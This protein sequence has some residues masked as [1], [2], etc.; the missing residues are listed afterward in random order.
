M[1]NT[2]V[3]TALVTGAS[4]G[5]GAAIA[6]KLAARG[7]MVIINYGHS[8]AAA[9]EVK[10]Q[11][12]QAGGQA[13]LMQ[14][15]VSS[16]DDVDRMFKDI[17]KTWGKLDVLV[18]NAGINR[19]TLLVRMKEDQ[20][21]A[22]LSTD[23]KSVFFTTKAAASLMMRQ[24]SGSII[25][26]ASVVGITGNAGQAN[27]AAAKAGV[28]GFTK[29]AAKELAARGIRV[30]AIAPGFIE[31][32][33]TDAIPE[34]I[35]EGMLETIPLRRGGKAEDVAN[36]VAFLASDDAGYITGQVLK[37]DGGMVM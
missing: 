7:F 33:M 15:D 29:S 8:S 32:D 36:A 27:Y 20:W 4:R 24:R 35:R 2:A 1:E 12:E 23:L 16:G 26:I 5:I 30:N 3:K 22:V 31:T 11:I 34:K 14:G 9:E 18:N 13:V 10:N 37:V 21:D 6:K 17:K 25:N 19:D 28:I